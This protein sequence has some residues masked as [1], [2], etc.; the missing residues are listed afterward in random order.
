[1]TEPDTP[2]IDP[3][4]T[5]AAP[6][7]A[8]AMTRM[9]PYRRLRHWFIL[10]GSAAVVAALYLT[11]PDRGL[12]TSMLLLSLVTP[13]LAVLFAHLSRK[14]MHDYPE[15]DARRLFARAAEHPIGAGLALVA[16]AIVV[17]ALLGL[18][19][20]SAHAAP[21]DPA[22]HIPPRALALLPTVAAETAAHWPDVPSVAYVPALIEHE[23]CLHLAHLRCWAPDAELRTSREQGVGLGQLTRAWHPDGS[24]RFDTLADLRAQ[25]P[26]LR[27]LTW[28]NLR[29]HPDL[30][31]RAVV[32][33]SRGNWRALSPLVTDP[34]ERLA[35]TDA[36]YNG[37]LAGV[38]R[39]RRACHIATACDPGRWWGHV[40]HHCSK[41][42]QPLYAGRS[43]CDINRHHVADVLRTRLPKYRDALLRGQHGA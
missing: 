33:L 4:A 39:E 40:E 13:L 15:A 31:V 22:R 7:A 10:G 32:L 24:L 26:A 21:A 23:S 6:L 5:P 42:R 43:A 37:G 16:L 9:P 19:G 11:D 17:A 25:H 36:A 12:S 8:P 30:Q 3:P 1:M 18:F 2:R 27:D 41:S 29:A 34:W 14:A 28:S 35:M 20:R 38:Q